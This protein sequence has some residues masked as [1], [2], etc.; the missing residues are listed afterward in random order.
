MVSRTVGRPANGDPTETRRR[1]LESARGRFARFGVQGAS[2]RDIATAAGIT[3]ATLNHHFGSK[4]GLHRACVAA[5]EADVGALGRKL[6]GAL[7]GA[8]SPAVLLEQA[9]R[10]GWRFARHHRDAVRMMQRSI[11]EAGEV[12]ERIRG[13]RV[14]PMLETLSAWLAGATGRDATSFRLGLQSAT[15]LAVRWAMS[16][17]AE[18]A[19]FA[20]VADAER[21]VEDHLVGATLGL[22]GLARA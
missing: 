20:G 5:F 6:A 19:A 10:E 2:V 9:V 17:D 11:A 15:F 7:G 8:A 1:I 16:S 4:E 12:D 13:G 22:L 21:A 14:V 18:L 3:V